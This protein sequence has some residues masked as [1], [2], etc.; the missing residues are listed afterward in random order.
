VLFCFFPKTVDGLTA[1]SM[2]TRRYSAQVL[3]E[4]GN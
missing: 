3:Q 2:V 1:K 4:L